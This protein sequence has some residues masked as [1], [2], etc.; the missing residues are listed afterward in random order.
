[1]RNIIIDSVPD[2]VE[3]AERIKYDMSS[4]PVLEEKLDDSTLRG[5]HKHNLQVIKKAI[6]QA[7]EQGRAFENYNIKVRGM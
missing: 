2:F 3:M 6:E 1:M 4:F 5:H 7:F